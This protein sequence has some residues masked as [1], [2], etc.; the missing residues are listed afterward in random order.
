MVNWQVYLYYEVHFPH[1]WQERF[2]FFTC[3]FLG[4][5]TVPR[6]SRE[7]PWQSN[8]G[9]LKLV[10]PRLPSG[11]ISWAP[12]KYCSAE[13]FPRHTR[14]VWTRLAID[15]RRTWLV[16]SRLVP[17]CIIFTLQV[18]FVKTWHLLQNSN[19]FNYNKN[20]KDKSFLSEPSWNLSSICFKQYIMS[21][22]FLKKKKYIHCFLGFLKSRLVLCEQFCACLGLDTSYCWGN[23]LTMN[24][25]LKFLPS[26][27]QCRHNLCLLSKSW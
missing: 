8:M 21:K 23:L 16:S 5:S 20:V 3:C 4:A 9:H 19:K 7:S 18:V 26:D 6:C 11:L 1:G 14:A 24:A 27:W 25:A 2:F 10:V 15:G 17:H 22:A 12:C 13:H